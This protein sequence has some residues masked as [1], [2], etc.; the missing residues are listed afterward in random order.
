MKREGL[1]G[2]HGFGVGHVSTEELSGSIK[3]VDGKDFI[4]H[5]ARAGIHEGIGHK[6]PNGTGHPDVMEQG[7]ERYDYTT[8]GNIMKTG[9]QYL[10]GKDAG[11]DRG[12][13][14]LP[15]DIERINKAIPNQVRACGPGPCYD[16]NVPKDNFSPKIK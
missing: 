9:D 8:K 7:A 3:A 13:F 5:Y 6:S 10:Y 12:D 4:G 16:L 1:G 11:Y 2:L 15:V 14:F